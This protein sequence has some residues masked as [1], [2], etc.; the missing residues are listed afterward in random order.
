MNVGSLFSGIGGLD[1]GLERAGMHI[2]WQCEIDPYC[3]T[4]LRK[5]WPDVPC[6]EDV[7]GVGT[8]AESV[9][10][11]CGGFPCQPTSQ[12]AARS[13][14]GDGWLWPEMA[15]IIARL[16]PR[17]VLVENPEGLRY[18]QRGLGQ[19]LDDLSFLGFAVEW[20]VVRAAEVG[21]S[22]QRA[23]IWVVAHS[24]TNGKPIFTLNDET[25]ILREPAPSFPDWETVPNLSLVDGI[26]ERLAI[27]ALGNAAV[28]Q[29]AEYV[30]RLIM[31]RE[32]QL[33]A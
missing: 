2:E 1:L 21:A 10:L 28:P 25:Q 14:R 30:G 11:I 5:H 15:G 24:Y 17:I 12:A 18:S 3:R 13:T 26:P 20:R 23:R 29:V 22:H 6:Y 19:I 4:V 32:E 16:Q 33:V 31:E 8:D 9:D 7:R 27:S